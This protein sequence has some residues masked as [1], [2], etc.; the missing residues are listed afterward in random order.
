MAK[1]TYLK[2]PYVV[3]VVDELSALMLKDQELRQQVEVLLVRS[4]QEGRA[5][6]INGIICTQKPIV[7]VVTP[8]LKGNLP[9]TWAFQVRTQS[10]SRVLLDCNGAEEL[11]GKGEF[12]FTDGG[13]A[14]IRGQ[15]GHLTET[16]IDAWI[17]DL[18]PQAAT[19]SL[20]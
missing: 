8:L 1:G 16:E 15:A 14:L 11:A 18:K 4:A 3:V 6:G 12:L 17:Q 20:H 5:A 9:A 13:A 7:D 2:L 10:D 19:Q